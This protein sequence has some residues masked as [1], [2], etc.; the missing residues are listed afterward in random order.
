MRSSPFVLVWL[1]YR[2]AVMVMTASTVPQAL[3]GPGRVRGLG[4]DVVVGGRGA[5]RGHS[6]C[7]RGGLEALD[8][9]P[10]AQRE[11]PGSHGDCCEH[12]QGGNMA[13]A[14]EQGCDDGE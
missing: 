14:A 11:L 1:R 3:G 4:G 8:D 12:G 7:D 9:Q 6:G 5:G 10:D 2:A 13:G